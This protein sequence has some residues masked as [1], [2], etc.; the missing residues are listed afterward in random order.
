LAHDGI[1]D[2]GVILPANQLQKRLCGGLKRFFSLN[3]TEIFYSKVLK[4]IK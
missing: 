1:S 2:H 4:E 3:L